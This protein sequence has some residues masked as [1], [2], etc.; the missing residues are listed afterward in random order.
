MSEQSPRIVERRRHKRFVL[1]LLGRFMRENKQE[2][3]CRV[4][5]ISVGGVAL[6]SPVEVTAGERIIAYLDEIGGLE[7]T[8]VRKFA[9]GFA[10]SLAISAHKREK[11]AAQITWLVNA[12]E[13]K[14]AEARRHS[15]MPASQTA[16]L[17]LEDGSVVPV[18]CLD[19]SLSGA[20]IETRM[21][22]AIGTPVTL[23]RLKGKVARHH[24]TGIAVQ[25]VAIQ[26]ADSLKR[27]FG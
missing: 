5:D 21:R 2:F 9:Q 13:F 14:G 18:R 11:L 23:G 15:R 25:F 26:N 17:T 10:L 4:I 24:G 22:P 12:H 3:T 19:V 27:H 8:V 1:P 20:S 6:A 7:G 16:T